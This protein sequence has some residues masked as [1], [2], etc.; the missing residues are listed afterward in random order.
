MRLDE[1]NPGDVVIVKGVDT[2]EQS[3]LKLMTF[4]I[5]EGSMVRCISKLYT[6]MEIDLYGTRFAI[7]NHTANAFICELADAPLVGQELLKL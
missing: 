7:S 5:V 1:A 3:T 6:S 4:G 2:S